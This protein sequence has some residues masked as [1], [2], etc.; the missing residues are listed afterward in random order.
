VS[1]YDVRR[2]TCI[3][4]TA[5]QDYY[6]L[7]VPGC[8]QYFANGMLHHNSGKTFFII[9]AIITR[10][11]KA[12]G[13]RHVVF[14]QD[15]V[16]AKQSIGNETVP[17][18]IALAYPGLELKWREKDG[19]YEAPNGSQL[20]LAGLKDKE[21]LDKVLGK[22]FVTIYLNEASQITLEALR[23][24]LTR[25]AQ[26]VMQT[27]G[28]KLTQK[29]YVDLNPTVAAHWTYQMWIL[30]LRPDDSTKISDPENYASITINPADN[31]ANLD[32]IY[33]ES[34]ANMPE[35]MRRRFYDGAFT[36]DDDN[37]IWRRSYIQYDA[38][39]TM[40]RIVV[41][42]DPATTSEVGSD[43]TGIIVAGIGADGRGYVI[44][45][46]S[47][48][49]RPEEWAR[50]A[51]SLY[52]TYDAD[53]IVA[54]KNQGGDMVES[55]VKAAA[56]GR[57]VPYHGVTATRAKH[58]RAEPVA[59]LYEQ[60]RVR[61]AEA[62]PELEDEMCFVAGTLVETNTGQVA[63]ENVRAG[64]MVLTR[65]GFRKVEVACKTGTAYSVVD[66]ASQDG[67]A[68]TCTENHPIFIRDKFVPASSV[69]P[70]DVLFGSPNWASTGSLLLG[71]GAG[72]TEQ[73]QDTSSM[74]KGL[75][76]T[77]LSGNPT[78]ARSRTGTT[79]TT[80]TLIRA[81]TAWKTLRAYLRQSTML[82]TI[83]AGGMAT[84]VKVGAVLNHGWGVSGTT[85]HARIVG[86]R[87]KRHI[88]TNLCSVLP[89]A[90][91]EQDLLQKLWSVDAPIVG[92]P[93]RHAIQGESIAVA[94]VTTRRIMPASVYNL[95]VE[96]LPEFFANGILTHNCAF[97]V[98]FDRKAQG[99]SPDRVDALVWAFTDLFP[100]M[101]RKPKR[102]AAVYVP[103][104][105]PMAG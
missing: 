48:K 61:H 69:R 25:L 98:G 58:I 73:Y 64:D 47:G 33:I 15:G 77:G 89:L 59:A 72:I 49:Y 93:M 13:S 50:R 44:A 28:R 85:K 32:P 51:V 97:T 80:K 55:M 29:L 63:I 21:R 35:R 71:G 79:F 75:C 92:T 45:D 41:S 86:Q 40:S 102:A 101:T 3:T 65:A 8:A 37:A 53:C 91:K 87:T 78:S 19:Y 62:F 16:D 100:A 31:A 7:H 96:G 38:L 103:L 57:T 39:P 52:D 66:I 6:T 60:G 84:L 90:G 22:E 11:L 43:L 36:A 34:L 82:S 26:V 56:K 105:N 54:E 88:R 17:A 12:P 1:G 27:D 4:R 68:I 42:I 5:K 23:V 20:W 81:T 99:Y 30:G 14:R 2:V 24:V 76:C 9:Y 70:G 95:K 74:L 104:N 46:E 18:V 10:M 83:L 94:H 67:R